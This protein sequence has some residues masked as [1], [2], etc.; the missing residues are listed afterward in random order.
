MAN[1]MFETIDNAI[2]SVAYFCLLLVVAILAAFVLYF[3][4]MTAYRA[5][6]LCW[7]ILFSHKWSL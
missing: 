7:D 1:N 4:A 2:K 5:F 6:W 3:V